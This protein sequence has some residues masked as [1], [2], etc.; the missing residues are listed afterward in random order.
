MAVATT[1]FDLTQTDRLLTTTRSVRKRLD[2][3]RDV[4]RETLLE[5]LSIALQAPSGGNTQPWRWLVVDDA[6]TKEQIA[7]LYRKSHDPYQDANRAALKQA[8]RTDM[9][10]IIDSSSYLSDHMHEVPVLVIPC[11]L[12]RLPEGASVFDTAGFYGSILPAA[13]SFM[14]ALRSRGIGAAWTTLHLAYEREVGEILGIPETVTQT[15]LI[16]VAYYTGTDFKPARRKPIEEVTY[17]NGWKK[18]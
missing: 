1:G 17:F 14:L 9:D 16:P 7:E 6:D 18:R 2:L 3:T 11:L 4:P 10:T 15:A 13:W 12:A 5:A 8:G